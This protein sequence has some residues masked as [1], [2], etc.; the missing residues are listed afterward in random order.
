VAV[1]RTD[2]SEN[3]IAAI[4]VVEKSSEL[5]KAL[6]RT[7]VSKEYIISIIRLKRTSE[8]ASYF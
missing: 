8:L 1:V 3:R 5:I 7:E 2:V 6:V 4:I